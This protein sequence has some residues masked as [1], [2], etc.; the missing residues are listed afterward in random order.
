[1]PGPDRPKRR[2]HP[3]IGPSPDRARTHCEQFRYDPRRED[4]AVVE[5]RIADEHRCR[6]RPA[7]M[8]RTRLALRTRN[9]LRCWCRRDAPPECSTDL[10]ELRGTEPHSGR[11]VTGHTCT[12]PRTRH[13]RGVSWCSAAAAS[14]SLTRR[15]WW[16]RTPGGGGSPSRP[17]ARRTA[18][19]SRAHPPSTRRLT[20]RSRRTAAARRARR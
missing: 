17:G 12:T 19:G 4:F 11:T 6:L 1:M 13:L 15:P 3:C 14:G 9:P 10:G 18:R 5:F 20:G 16:A 2:Q 8:L 7:L